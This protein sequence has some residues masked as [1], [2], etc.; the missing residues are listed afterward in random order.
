MARQN[1]VTRQ[2][3]ERAGRRA[4]W[5][6]AWALRLK[7]Y[8]ILA[9]RFRSGRGEID[10]VARKGRQLIFVEVKARKTHEDAKQALTPSGE[11]RIA[12]AAVIW[13]SRH[14][15]HAQ[16]NIRYDL[17][18]VA[19]VLPRHHQDAFRPESSRHDPAALF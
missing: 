10:L 4:E 7:G 14:T 18:T 2:A 12:A 6:A 1:S 8:R 16:H 15:E 19:G 11:K 5:I 13:M 9:E 17:I 3:R